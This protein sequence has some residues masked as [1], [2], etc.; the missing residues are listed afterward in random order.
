MRVSGDRQERVRGEL[1]TEGGIRRVVGPVSARICRGL[2]YETIEEEA[3]G[4][5]SSTNSKVSTASA[6][7]ADVHTVSMSPPFH[8]PTSSEFGP[9]TKLGKV[10]GNVNDNSPT[11]HQPVYIVDADAAA[12]QQQHHQHRRSSGSHDFD[13][14][15]WDDERG[16]VALRKYYAPKDETQTTVSES[17]MVWLD[18]PFSLFAIQCGFFSF[19]PFGF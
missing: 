7:A 4:L 14:G 9:T 6:D 1:G 3:D 19:L 2:V 18:T 10:G 12:L 17:R 15:V 16:I 11:I 5:G 8:A 13:F